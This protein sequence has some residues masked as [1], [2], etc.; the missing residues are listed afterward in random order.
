MKTLFRAVLTYL[1]VL[2]ITITVGILFMDK[3]PAG[4]VIVYEVIDIETSAR[5]VTTNGTNLLCIITPEGHGFTNNPRKWSG[6][7][8]VVIGA[9]PIVWKFCRGNKKKLR[10][11]CVTPDTKINGVVESA[12]PGNEP[13]L[14]M[15]MREY[16]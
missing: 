7:T 13:K 9:D 5:V 4:G 12:N 8:C 3:A 15:E 6:F 14:R 1:I 2:I 11:L 10:L 16:N